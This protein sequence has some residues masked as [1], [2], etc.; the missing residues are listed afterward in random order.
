MNSKQFE[1]AKMC[2]KV[3][4][5]INIADGIV[6]GAKDYLYDSRRQKVYFLNLHQWHMFIYKHMLLE[7][8]ESYLANFRDKQ[9]LLEWLRMQG[10]DI[11]DVRTVITSE[12]QATVN[13]MDSER[14]K[15]LNDI[16][17]HI[18]Q[19]D[20]SLYVPG[21]S[22]KGVF[23]TA[24]L[25][26]L[27]QKRQDIKSKYWRQIQGKISNNYLNPKRDFDGLAKDLESELLHTLRLKDDK[28]RNIS[29]KNAV[30]SAMRGLQ[31]SDTY[32]SRNVQTAILQ[33]VD[34]G[35]DKFGKA[36]PKK[37]PIFRECMLPEAELFFDVKVEKAVMNTIGI[38]S[39][40]DLLKAT[41][42][43]FAA[44]TDLLQQAFGKEYQ[45]AFQGV[46]AGN[47]FLGGNTGF[48]S[49]T[50]LAM[51]APD[52][53]TAKNTIK[54]LLDKSFKTHKHLLRDKIIAP[55]TLKCTNYNGKLMLMG[56]AEVRK[57]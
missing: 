3:V 11:D 46:A 22:I 56:V 17:R 18:Q 24:V 42:S 47:M 37:L 32:A 44:V 9:S 20:G 13:L 48:L 35:F 21:S 28:E 27:L 53:D 29:N 38:N 36:S 39:V 6:L 14:K 19:P 8:Y 43:F 34:G 57:V 50:L 12:A 31:V 23:R 1:T 4:T 15:T 5:P 26:K 2:L 7:K 49:K 51:L 45:E 33:K 10:Y 55:R 30:C 25:Y 41:H 52:K 16:N 40:G 54:V